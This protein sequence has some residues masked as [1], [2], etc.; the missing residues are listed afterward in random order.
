METQFVCI[1][2]QSIATNPNN[3]RKVFD[4][5]A[6]EELSASIIE[7]GVLQP[8]VVRPFSDAE[9]GTE[10]QLV[11]GERRW[12]AA[13]MAGLF[14]IPAII[15]DLTDDEAM[16]VAITENLQRKDV[17][18]LEEANAFNYLLDKGS[19][20]A[21]LCGRFGKSEFY[22]RGR[23]K[24]LSMNEDFRKLLDAGTISISQAM[25]IVKFD[26]DVQARM[27]ADHFANDDYNSWR[28]MTGRNIYKRGMEIFTK[29]LGKYKFDKTDCE[30]CPN[31]TKNSCLFAAIEEAACQDSVCLQ[32][33]DQEY[34]IGVAL[35]IQKQHPE[36][37]FMTW[38]KESKMKSELEG[39]GYE[40]RV[41]QSRLNRIGAVVSHD[42]KSRAES[43]EIQLF[44]CIDDEPYLGYAEKGFATG[45][46]GTPS[47]KIQALRDKDIRNKEIAEEK[48]VSDVRD[49][50][51]NM[52][53][54]TLSAGELTAYEEQL[55]LYTL[56]K[57]LKKEQQ[58]QV[59]TV[60]YYTMSDEEAWN[61]VL[62]A[63]AEQSAYIQ[64]CNI[65]NHVGDHTRKD[66]QTDL[67]FEW[68][69]SQ[70]EAIVPAADLKHR[71]VYL[72]RHEKIE[73]R[74]AEIEMAEVE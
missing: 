23:L 9:N 74:I 15:R 59:G 34:K 71:E 72:K 39:L 42:L 50:I 32:Q 33:K 1:D 13:G 37:D 57:G 51:K 14:E 56:L 43:G 46:E 70:D 3:P 10:Y 45:L 66:F 36:A 22:V 55:T 67:F 11:C 60:E 29:Q 7:K 24:L 26:G 64:R 54:D 48:T 65:L 41:L 68:V 30:K 38:R 44:I 35:K 73:A 61:T 2:I 28:T 20:I 8:I 53:A 18:P 52:D 31:C 21:D 4:S 27:Y 69:N 58:E 63:S 16:D 12:R 5:V 19:S 40:V 17:S 49:A 62:H 47:A 6:L 25:E